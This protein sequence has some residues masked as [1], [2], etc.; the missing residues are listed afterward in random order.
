MLCI[1][2]ETLPRKL[3]S[4]FSKLA[5]DAV[6]A[7]GC[8]KS[9]SAAR[10]HETAPKIR[11]RL[12]QSI[13][14]PCAIELLP[15]FNAQD[16]TGTGLLCRIQCPPQSRHPHHEGPAPVLSTLHRAA[17][18]ES[19]TRLVLGPERSYEQCLVLFRAVG[20]AVLV[21][22]PAY[23]RIIGARENINAMAK[24]GW[25]A[26]APLC[27]TSCLGPERPLWKMVRLRKRT[28]SHAQYERGLAQYLY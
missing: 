25:A 12:L 8:R 5:H 28:V 21:T 22:G 9:S 4:C 19:M 18:P 14:P 2:N 6:P 11:S 3:G 7:V 10:R 17:Q 26:T 24:A 27:T 13:L 23:G 15:F 16:C 20:M 1:S